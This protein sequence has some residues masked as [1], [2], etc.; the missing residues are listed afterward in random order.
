MEVLIENIIIIKVHVQ[1]LLE[2]HQKKNYGQILIRPGKNIILL[3]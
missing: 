2:E 1:M 3:D